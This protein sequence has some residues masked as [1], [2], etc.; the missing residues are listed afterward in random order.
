MDLDKFLDAL[1]ELESFGQ[2]GGGLIGK[3]KFEVAFFIYSGEVDGDEKMYPFKPGDQD[4]MQQALADANE[5]LAQHGLDELTGKDKQRVGPHPSYVTTFY[6]ASA[7][8]A[9]AIRADGWQD[10][11]KFALPMWSDAAKELWR[12]AIKELALVPGTYW[13]RLTFAEDPSGRMEQGLDGPR[14]ALVAY[15][16]ELYANEV[17]AEDAAGGDGNEDAGTSSGLSPKLA[18]AVK[19]DYEAATATG[20][21]PLKAAKEVAEDWELTVDEVLA[22]VE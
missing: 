21:S 12:P 2:G 22:I 14:V 6:K 4:S 11:R 13:G 17:G 8:G 10:D 9:T 7:K 15:P 5:T 1:D 18:K 19:G 3:F 16:A 20:K